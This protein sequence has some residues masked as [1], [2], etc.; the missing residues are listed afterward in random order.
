[1]ITEFK[2][3]NYRGIRDLSVQPIRQ[4][5]LITGTNGAGK[6]SLAEAIWI[7]YGRYNPSI[8]W[9]GNIQRRSQVEG[10]SPLAGLG[11][12]PVE[13]SGTESGEAYGVKF[14]YEE[15]ISALGESSR[16]LGNLIVG[17]QVG[18]PLEVQPGAVQLTAIGEL[19][20]TYRPGNP[21]ESIT[22]PVSMGPSGPALGVKQLPRKRP[23]GLLVSRANSYPVDDDTI[24][25]FSDVIAKGERG[26]L[27]EMLNLIQPIV[28]DLQVLYRQGRASVWAELKSGESL[29]FESL[30]GGAVRLL[31]L[32]VNFY[33]VEG[34][35][36]V[37]DEIDNGI[38]YRSLPEMWKQIQVLCKTL[39]VQ[40]V[41]TTHSFECVQAASS[42][43]EDGRPSPDFALHHLHSKDGVRQTESYTDEKLMGALI[44]GFEV[45]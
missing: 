31:N 30:G 20:A 16:P 7:F 35:I 19:V 39:N 44:L 40:C 8:L 25:R 13:L 24:S 42:L 43:G 26:R 14:E 32:F 18:S 3:V 45:R 34:G 36:I 10:S 5:N 27:M 37:I 4:I 12:N 28:K 41:A 38:H 6:T 9:T 17:G 21:N 15:T 1:M 33:A 22:F 2:I 29:P 11:E 23:L